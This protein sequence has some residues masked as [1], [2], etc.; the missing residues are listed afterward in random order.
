M[1][2]EKI[3]GIEISFPV[4]IRLSQRNQ[5]DLVNLVDCICRRNCPRD[6]VMW[7]GGIGSKIISFPIT[8]EQE[9]AGEHLE[10]DDSVFTISCSMRP[11]YPTDKR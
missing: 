2:G 10:F 5:I 8:Q 3:T 1:A 6:K 9:D 4:P 11:R 7:P